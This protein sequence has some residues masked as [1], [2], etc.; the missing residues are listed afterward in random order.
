MNLGLSLSL[1]G[2]RAGGGP[3]P[4]GL[5][6]P[7]Y[8][9]FETASAIDGREGWTWT[10]GAPTASKT[11]LQ[12]IGGVARMS[13]DTT[14]STHYAFNE[15]GADQD[16]FIEVDMSLNAA[17]SNNART[18]YLRGSA[19]SQDAILCEIT[20]NNQINFRKRV[21]GSTTFIA[22]SG[23]TFVAPTNDSAV[24][25]FEI[26]A[27]NVINVQRNG[28]RF[29]D[30]RTVSAPVPSGTR[31]GL[32]GMFFASTTIA[33]DFRA[34]AI[35]LT[36]N[37][38]HSFT[39]RNPSTN[40]GTVAFSGIY[41]GNLA[42]LDYEVRDFSADTLVQAR[43][44]FS[45]Q[46]A[47]AGAWTGTASVPTGDANR[48]HVDYSNDDAIT[49]RSTRAI[50]GACHV[51]WGQ[52]EA[53]S[54]NTLLT[55]NPAPDN[56]KVNT[57][58]VNPSPRSSS[59]WIYSET[60]TVFYRR[61]TSSWSGAKVLSDLSGVPHGFLATGVAA[62]ALTSLIPGDAENLWD[63]ILVADLDRAGIDH[64][65]SVLLEQG[66]AEAW[67]ASTTAASNW[68]TPFGTFR[69]SIR[70]LSGDGN[71][72]VFV[73]QIPYR[74]TSGGSF[75][76]A[77]NIMR[78]HIASLHNP[79]NNTFVSHSHLAIQKIGGG[80]EHANAVGGAELARRHGL[81][82]ARW[83]YGLI[84]YDGRGPLPGTP[85][86][87]GATITVPI[88][89]NGASSIA[90]TSLSGWV[91]GTTAASLVDANS[92]LTITSVDVSGS[93]IVIVLAADPGAPVWVASHRGHVVS[94][95]SLAIGTYADATTIPVFPMQ[96]TQTTT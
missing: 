68:L 8:D 48:L 64:F 94:E 95:S 84:A 72:P 60:D 22:S 30:P 87:S 46:S 7:F 27:A 12:A 50:V 26:N 13:V 42:A 58:Y 20:P 24:Y 5:T 52:S 81:S 43:T 38:T 66:I 9:D 82:V 55:N 10:T 2:M 28:T 61:Q 73:S 3:V 93:N 44:S 19:D 51:V 85:T 56:F 54:Y 32:G 71:L 40:L 14:T 89:L 11:N 70:T 86:R 41:K 80:D 36:A 18:F 34:G 39:A 76:T 31:A 65:E 6:A 17:A 75:D 53:G 25:R 91:V 62:R 69:T 4:S 78:D 79:A 33:R 57:F 1:G 83:V 15:I 29:S 77:C 63:N 35:N 90:G 23:G 45:P 59:R 67:A 47:T 37:P 92:P 21:A 16:Q 49:A 74:S 96:P 88:D